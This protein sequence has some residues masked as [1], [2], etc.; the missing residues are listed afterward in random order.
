MPK[1]V[2]CKFKPEDSRA[3]TYLLDGHDVV[4]GDEV[5][6]P[7][8]RS[9]GWKRVTV[10]GFTDD[11]PAFACKAV[12]GLAPK[13]EEAIDLVADSATDVLDRDISAE[14]NPRRNR[15]DDLDSPLAF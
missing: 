7:D 14:T 2:L 3:Y 13:R 4:I 5:K 8:N 11:E 15:G 9:D 10:A 1:Y 12:L 6:V